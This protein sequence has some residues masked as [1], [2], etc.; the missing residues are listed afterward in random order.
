M[1]NLAG[2][3]ADD[4]V[5]PGL[6]VDD[7]GFEMEAQGRI[8]LE[9][10]AHLLAGDQLHKLGDIVSQALHVLAHMIGREEPAQEGPEPCHGRQ[11]GA[12]HHPGWFAEGSSHKSGKQ[13]VEI[14]R[15]DCPLSDGFAKV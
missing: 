14:T 15:D 8:A 2:A 12:G 6:V 9:P 13:R 11:Y 5:K 4:G 7:H 10:V 3:G 1:R